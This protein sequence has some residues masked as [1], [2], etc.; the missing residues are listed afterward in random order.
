MGS[1]END[2]TLTSTSEF[3]HTNIHNGTRPSFLASHSFIREAD[4][5]YVC[6]HNFYRC[7]HYIQQ[8]AEQNRNAKIA[9]YVGKTQTNQTYKHEE[10]KGRLHSENACY[11]SFDNPS[12]PVSV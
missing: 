11:N 7:S 9:K 1:N 10:I 3:T 8:H 12:L 4:Y 6:T 2:K 5:S